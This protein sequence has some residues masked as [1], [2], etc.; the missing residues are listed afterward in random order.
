MKGNTVDAAAFRAP[1]A[2]VDGERHVTGRATEC[3]FS[4]RRKKAERGI[5]P[6]TG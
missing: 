2:D 6:M 3:E 1:A 5:P 4:C